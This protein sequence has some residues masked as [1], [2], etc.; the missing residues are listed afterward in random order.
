ML[1]PITAGL[2]N[3]RSRFEMIGHVGE[4]GGELQVIYGMYAI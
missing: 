4:E 2:S 3:K 1:L